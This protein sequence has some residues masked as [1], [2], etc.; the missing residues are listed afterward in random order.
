MKIYN[1]NK[2]IKEL[3]EQGQT[4]A[5]K[6]L[7]KEVAELENVYQEKLKRYEEKNNFSLHK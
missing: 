6:K 3:K 2:E 1:K 4:F 5:A 7:E